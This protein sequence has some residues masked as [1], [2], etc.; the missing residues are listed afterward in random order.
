MGASWVLPA[1]TSLAVLTVYLT[2]FKALVLALS[3]LETLI[4]FFK[5]CLLQEAR[6]FF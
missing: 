5:A 2:H 3:Q 6:I 4:S 1:L